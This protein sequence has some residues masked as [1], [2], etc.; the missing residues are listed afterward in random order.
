MLK[1]SNAEQTGPQAPLS[2][3]WVLLVALLLPGMGQV[4]NNTPWRGLFMAC[5]MVIL[6]L[7]TF[8]LAA[9]GVSWVGK[10]A[11]GKL[12]VPVNT[13]VRIILEPPGCLQA[14]PVA[15]IDV[16][17]RISRNVTAIVR[18]V[19]LLTANARTVA[20]EH[21]RPR[22]AACRTIGIAQGLARADIKRLTAIFEA[23]GK[24]KALR[25]ADD[26]LAAYIEVE[27]CLRIAQPTGI[28][29][30]WRCGSEGAV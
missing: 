5:F 17:L 11:G 28:E 4:L 19:D 30:L 20:W 25:E 13:K 16:Q 15:N 7:I 18:L 23:A 8:N 14:E 29:G 9:V 24:R 3:Y 6:G 12:A 21:L 26:E 2:P 10:L 27:Q 22:C 1:P